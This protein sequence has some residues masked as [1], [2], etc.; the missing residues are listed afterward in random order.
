MAAVMVNVVYVRVRLCV[1]MCARARVCVCVCVR[2]RERERERE[3]ERE[4]ELE[5]EIE[6][7]IVQRPYATIQTKRKEKVGGK[8]V[9]DIFIHAEIPIL[10]DKLHAS[11]FI[12]IDSITQCQEFFFFCL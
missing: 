2:K 4:R 6:L 10:V 1:C 9:R 5:L 12:I 3:K 7:C 8:G 11:L